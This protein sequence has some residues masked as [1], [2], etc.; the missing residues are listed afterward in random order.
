MIRV[1]QKQT[2][3]LPS[4]RKLVSDGNIDLMPVNFPTTT[5]VSNGIDYTERPSITLAS[6]AAASAGVDQ[7]I[8]VGPSEII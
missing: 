5:L 8:S 6:S 3:T 4:I 7:F 1:A 2:G